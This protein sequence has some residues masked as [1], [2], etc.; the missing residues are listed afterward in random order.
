MPA[1]PSVLFICQHNSGRSQMAEAYLKRMARDLLH[2][3]SAGLEPAERVNPLV[4]EVMKEEGFDLSSKKPRSVFEL[5]KAGR[6]F[7][8][9]ITVCYDSESKCPVF[10]GITKRWHWPFPDP[11]KVTGSEAEKLEKVR[12]IR[13]QIKRWLSDPPEGG[14][15]FKGL[16]S[17]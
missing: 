4:V 17:E 13:D 7:S 16:I 10:P 15:S 14:F 9:V 12:E 6:L 11:A 2:V 5:F 3:E 1:K 8:H